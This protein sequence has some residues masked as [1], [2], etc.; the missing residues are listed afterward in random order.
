MTP[1]FAFLVAHPA[2]SDSLLTIAIRAVVERKVIRRISTVGEANIAEAILTTSVAV[3]IEFLS[4]R[5]RKG[6]CLCGAHKDAVAAKG[7]N[8]QNQPWNESQCMDQSKERVIQ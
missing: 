2:I 5:I 8:A 4:G 7:H 6:A 3:V 1:G